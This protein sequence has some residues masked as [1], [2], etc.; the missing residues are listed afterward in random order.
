MN[1]SMA[2]SLTL[3]RVSP[4]L[5]PDSTVLVFNFLK[6]LARS[7]EEKKGRQPKETLTVNAQEAT[8]TTK[9]F[10][11]RRNPGMSLMMM[12]RIIKAWDRGI[13]VKKVESKARRRVKRAK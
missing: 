1:S 5:L 3:S 4:F 12:V 8:Y 10:M 13:L 9:I 6:Y 7:L 11:G 2:T